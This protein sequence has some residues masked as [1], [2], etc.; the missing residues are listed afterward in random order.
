MYISL[1]LSSNIFLMQYIAYIDNDRSS[2][3]IEI[4]IQVICINF[5]L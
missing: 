1:L 4:V 2:N 5:Y 3:D